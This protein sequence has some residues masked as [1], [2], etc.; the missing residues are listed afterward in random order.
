MKKSLLICSAF[1]ALLTTACSKDNTKSEYSYNI[2][3]LNY[4]SSMDGT[5]EPVIS[6]SYY[7]Y[8]MDMVA[9][10]M[11][12][13]AQVGTSTNGTTQFTTSDLSFQ[14]LYYNIDGSLVEIIKS[15]SF[16]AGKTDSGDPINDFYCELTSLVNTPPVIPGL[17]DVVLPNIKY[18]YMHYNIGSKYTVRTFWNDL[19][20]S[21]YT[22]TSYP[23]GSFESK[24]ILYRVVM[25]VKEK[26]AT[27]ILYNAQFAE[28]MP[29]LTNIVLKDL[30]I[31]FKNQG[32]VIKASN[33]TPEI[34][35][36]G[37]GTPNNK[38]IFNSFELNSS[39]DLTSANC[40][41]EVNG[42]FNGE[43]SGS[44][45]TTLKDLQEEEE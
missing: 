26:K 34:Y 14:P 6:G 37:E 40:Y 10:T 39:G 19:T 7:N 36:S 45:I 31:D 5:G 44:Y 3:I 29:E 27:V 28:N 38:F 17:P 1:A 24:N 16:V 25:N 13:S 33:V 30:P 22:N 23:G 41:Y 32:Y 42:T 43:F 12:V 15:E 8:K 18:T 4:V 2:P 21:G 11:V 9:S 20:F 35:E